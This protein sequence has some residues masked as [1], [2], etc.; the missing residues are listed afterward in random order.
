[1]APASVEPKPEADDIAQAVALHQRGRLNEAAQ[2]YQAILAAT[3]DHPDALNL[4]GL[5]LHQQNRNIEALQLIGAAL[6]HAAASAD[7]VN[8]FALVLDALGR[9]EEALAHFEQALA[10]NCC[11]V[12]ALNNRANTL[13]RLKR[14]EEALAAY[15]RLL[16]LQPG[17]LGALNESGGL[18]M[19]LGRPAAALVCYDRALAVSA[20]PELHVNR[21]AALRALQR[22]AEALASFAMA[23]ALKPD[24]AEAHWNAS[25]IRLRHGDFSNGWKEYEWRWRKADWARRRRIFPAPLWLGDAPLAGATILLHAEQGFGDTIQFIRYAPLLARSGARVVLECPVELTELLRD[26]EG[27]AEI[28]AHGDRLPAF[29]FHCPLLSL[30][31]AFGTRLNTIPNA[32]AYVKA[33]ERR[34]RQWAVQLAGLPKPRVGLVW[35]GNS[36]H[37]SDRHRSIALPALQPL[38]ALAGLHFVN[39]QKH[40]A[41]ADMALLARF[42][43]VVDVARELRDFADTA[44]VIAQLDL[45]VAVDTA[46]AHLAGAMGKAVALLL[47]YSPD[48]RWMLDRSDSP[49]YPTMRLFRQT[50]LGDWDGVI[51]RLR[52]ELADVAC[53]ATAQG[54]PT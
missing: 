36:A 27:V 6:K 19:R 29:D 37:H 8:N 5:V 21:G 35:A 4:L 12:N 53:R 49:W 10:V 23:A 51:E 43:N 11:H 25:L 32:V 9:H 47:P 3:P 42:A 54:A 40:A 22:D 24:F 31:L 48:F 28:V 16:E 26:S 45:V 2:L 20:L 38:L 41:A 44:A 52:V 30:P 17:H 7:I 33:P 18:N 13:A 15:Q 1:M 14:D 34:L 50:A 46:V 39:L